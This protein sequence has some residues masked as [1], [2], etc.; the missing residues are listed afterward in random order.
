MR[1]FETQTLIP[2]AVY[3]VCAGLATSVYFAVT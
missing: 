2:F 1:F 3:C